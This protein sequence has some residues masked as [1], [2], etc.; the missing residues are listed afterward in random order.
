MVGWALWEAG[1][2]PAGP[3]L[4]GEAGAEPAGGQQGTALPTDTSELQA[5]FPSPQMRHFVQSS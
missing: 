2:R 3:G 4:V 5:L 1:P